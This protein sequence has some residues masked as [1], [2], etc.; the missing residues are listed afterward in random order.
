MIT[1][2]RKAYRQILTEPIDWVLLHD[3]RAVLY[4]IK[5]DQFVM[6]PDGE[7][8]LVQLSLKFEHSDPNCDIAALVGKVATSRNSEIFYWNDSF[9]LRAVDCTGSTYYKNRQ[10]LIYKVKVNNADELFSQLHYGGIKS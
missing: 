2:K 9:W 1:M 5:Y 4:H 6:T 3:S 10:Y 8:A 7:M